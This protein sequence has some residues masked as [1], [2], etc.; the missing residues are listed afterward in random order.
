MSAARKDKMVRFL[1]DRG[2][3]YTIKDKTGR[4]ALEIARHLKKDNIVV[5]LEEHRH[6]IQVR[7]RIGLMECDDVSF[8]FV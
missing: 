6:V 5:I 1:L 2:A 4:N 7:R 8:R 3:D